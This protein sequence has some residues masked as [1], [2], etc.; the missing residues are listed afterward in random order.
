MLNAQDYAKGLGDSQRQ[1][2]AWQ[3]AQST[4]FKAFQTAALAALAAV[5]AATIAFAADSLREFQTFEKGVNEVFTLL[6]GIS[7]DAMGQ[8]Q[9]DV[10]EFG[11][12]VGRTSD[13]VLPA[14]YQAISA[15]V[16]QENVFDFLQIA[17]DAALG[18]VTTLEVAVD[19][20]TSVVNAYGDSVI[21][22][23]TASDVMFTA[24]KL[25]KTDF[26]QLSKSLFN[27]VPTAASLG[28]TF[29]DVAANLAAL[30]AQGT[31]TS[32]ATTQLRAAFVEASKAGTKLDLALRDLTGKGFADLIADGKTSSQ[33]FTE[34]RESMP[35]QDFRD[36]FS[37]VEASNAVLGITND[38]AAGIIETFG[39]VEDTL[40]ATAEAAETMAQSMEHL[41]AQSL[42][43]TEALKIQTGEALEPLK[44]SWLEL[45]IATADYFSDD[46]A[47]RNQITATTDALKAQGISS[48]EAQAAVEALGEGTLLW[49][50]SMVDAETMARR[51]EIALDLLDNGFEG[52]E[53]SLAAQAVAIDKANQ[54][55]LELG[56]SYESTDQLLTNYVRTAEVAA[57]AQEELAAIQAEEALDAA[58]ALGEQTE[59]VDQLL[60][61]YVR[62]AEV[63]TEQEAALAAAQELEAEAARVAA[64]A[65]REHERALGSY[66]DSALTATGQTVSLERQLYD[67]A[68]ASGAG[69]AE[70]AVLA[71]AT[72]EFTD[73]EIEAAF[74]AA[75]MQANIDTLVAPMMA[76]DITAEEAAESL[77]ILQDGAADTAADAMN[78]AGNIV[79]L[80]GELDGLSGAAMDATGALNAIPTSIHTHISITSDP[81]PNMPGGTGGPGS[82]TGGG[83]PQAFAMGGFTGFG[84][85]TD[86]AG[87]VHA[88]ELVIPADVLED[89]FASML[90]FAQAEL[91]GNYDLE[92]STTATAVAA[93]TPTTTVAGGDTFNIYIP[94]NADPAATERVR[95]IVREELDRSGRNADIRVRIG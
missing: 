92:G 65:Q 87:F 24:V 74:Q 54:A 93:P 55:A 59:T 4:L 51:T 36:L 46:L 77:R 94:A 52:S 19:G 53:V 90:A 34:L 79:G 47:K 45:K 40:G 82:G 21:D 42:A 25:G 27:V 67:T 33:I 2:T 68:V 62:T 49:R 71:A 66:F 86:I 88:N 83:S 8:M 63:A 91:P 29:T 31:P 50:D 95:T 23:A 14:L 75:L 80:S 3:K 76:G 13:E 11:K 15:G 73:A 39:D 9:D 58:M 10:L 6:P 7:Q 44:R 72:G 20:I 48:L 43:A 37:S 60:T 69:A 5:V 89:G 35:E 28:V 57:E 85:N 78:L 38:T 61:N 56:Q 64:E 12:A 70:L 22:A 18:G 16:P 41:E 17:S 81:I 26:E 32:V 84:A 1:A 30:T